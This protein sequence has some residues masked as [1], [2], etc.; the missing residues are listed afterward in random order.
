MKRHCQLLR[1]SHP[2]PRGYRTL[3]SLDGY[4][5]ITRRL[6]LER[7]VVEVWP[8]QLVGYLFGTRDTGTKDPRFQTQFHRSSAS[9]LEGS[10]F[11]IRFHQ[12]SV[13]YV[14]LPHNKSDFEGQ[15]SSRWVLKQVHPD[16]G[17]SR[18]AMLIMNSFM[19][20]MF[21]R[22][23]AE[24]S[25]L[26][27]HNGRKVL[28]S[29]EIQTAVRLVLPDRQG[30][31][32]V[33]RRRWS[34]WLLPF[35][36][37]PLRELTFHAASRKRDMMG[38]DWRLLLLGKEVSHFIFRVS[39]MCSNQMSSS[40]FDNGSKLRGPSLNSPRVASKRDINIIYK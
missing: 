21:E 26:T 17:I 12:R 1:S 37:G 18:Q 39:D 35:L 16:C 34:H 40:S 23:S 9:E 6:W 15:T 22:I 3:T 29:R 7:V 19:N 10:R 28:S 2:V 8:P 25:D 11:E 33:L 36:H 5:S 31:D 24:S 13:V 38:G 14:G 4:L 30:M 27:K 20:D 32:H